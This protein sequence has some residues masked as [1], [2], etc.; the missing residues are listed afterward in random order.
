MRN[1]NSLLKFVILLHA[2]RI[3]CL[4]VGRR[5]LAFNSWD[6]DEA[7]SRNNFPGTQRKCT[8]A[9]GRA[10]AHVAVPAAARAVRRVG[11]RPAGGEASARPGR[12]LVS[13]RVDVA[14]PRG[15]EA[16]KRRCHVGSR[17]TPMVF[18]SM[19]RHV[20]ADDGRSIA[21]A[22]KERGSSPSQRVVIG[23]NECADVP[24]RGRPRQ[25]E[26]IAKGWL[27]CR[28][29]I[30]ARRQSD[31]QRTDC[32]RG[33]ALATNRMGSAN[34]CL[35]WGVIHQFNVCLRGQVAGCP[36]PCKSLY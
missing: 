2:A 7:G 36:V 13:R 1:S 10:A 32:S 8:R 12:A 29:I 30:D 4:C 22:Q 9:S 21:P 6:L 24:G 33:V 20:L 23:G 28:A 14:T 5:L 26:Y 25:R 19:H 3:A 31:Q 35:N 27:V 34:G 11:R 18:F 16:P 15:G 17:P